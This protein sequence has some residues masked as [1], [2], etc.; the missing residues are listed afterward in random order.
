MGF[1]VIFF[2]EG[3][4]HSL[5]FPQKWGEQRSCSE[6]A[7]LFCW[8]KFTSWLQILVHMV[9]EMKGSIDVRK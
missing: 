2:V 7:V 4:T 9:G 5:N 1:A 6:L 8:E 3:G